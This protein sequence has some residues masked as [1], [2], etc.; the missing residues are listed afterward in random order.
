MSFHIQPGWDH[1][2]KKFSRRGNF[3][4]PSFC[5][6]LISDAGLGSGILP[7]QAMGTTGSPGYVLLSISPGV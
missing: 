2:E 6:T 4:W 5:S 7:A 1:S 3:V